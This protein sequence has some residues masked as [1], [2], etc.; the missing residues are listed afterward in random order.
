MKKIQIRP[1][2]HLIVLIALFVFF[3]LLN[4]GSIV[5]YKTGWNELLSEMD[6]ILML[7]LGTYFLYLMVRIFILSAFTNSWNRFL[8]S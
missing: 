6:F 8:R 2:R 5:Y 4:A 1:V 7:T 3:N